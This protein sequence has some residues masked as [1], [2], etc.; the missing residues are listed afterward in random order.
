VRAQ[1][2]DK[3]TENSGD[4]GVWPPSGNELLEN[5]G[6]RIGLL[7]LMMIALYIASLLVR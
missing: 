3:V 4:A 1:Q 7:G 5:W 6:S 2:T